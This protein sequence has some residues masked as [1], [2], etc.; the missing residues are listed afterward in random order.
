MYVV[1]HIYPLAKLSRSQPTTPLHDWLVWHKAAVRVHATHAFWK[2]CLPKMLSMVQDAMLLYHTFAS[3]GP[4][5]IV[6]PLWPVVGRG[7]KSAHNANQAYNFQTQPG[8]HL[9]L[10]IGGHLLRKLMA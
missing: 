10:C 6:T 4:C 2:A 3:D 8:L 9:C 5:A 7:G 1:S